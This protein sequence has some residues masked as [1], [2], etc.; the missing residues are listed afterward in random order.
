MTMNSRER[1]QAALRGDIPDR[2]PAF[3]Q[4]LGGAK[5]VLQAAGMTMREGFHDPEVFA[6][7]CMKS[8]EL[9]RYDNVMSGWGD[10]L[11]EARALGSTWKFPERD[12]Y[13][14]IDKHFVQAPEDVDRLAAVDPL[15]D[16]FWSVPIRAGAILQQK[17]GKEVAVVGSVISP[18]FVAT[19]LRGY[20]NLMMD[21]I[22]DPSL[23]HRMVQVA[24]DSEKMYGERIAAL[25]L[26]AV[27]LDDSSASGSL[28]SPETCD[29]YD[30]A[31]LRPLLEKFKGL[32][33]R[34]IVHNDSQFPYL[35]QQ[36]AAGAPCTHFNNDFVD[37]PQI[38][39]RYRGKVTLMSGINHQEVIF[40]RSPQDVEDQVRSVIELYGREPGLIVA[41]GS[42]IPFKSPIENILRVREACEKFGRY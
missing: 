14:R 1:F 23:V 33:L 4:Q 8:H 41:P 18:F 40:K 21:T 34:T 7:I 5:H 32:G 17:I 35:D 36:I 6:K 38:F 12:F 25:G 28:V 11:T 42:E 30:L 31:Y 2:V 13:P 9:F 19:E 26:E 24:L 20:E 37:L 27:F 29:I 3:Y 22:S 16:E 10:L 39:S 15:K